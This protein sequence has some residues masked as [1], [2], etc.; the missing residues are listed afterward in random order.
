MPSTGAFETC[1]PGPE[2]LLAGPLVHRTPPR[3]NLHGL[4]V[5]LVVKIIVDFVGR[6]TRPAS[7]IELRGVVR[8]AF[9]HTFAETFPLTYARKYHTTTQDELTTDW[10]GPRMYRPNLE[11]IFRG[12]LATARRPTS[13][14]SPTSATRRTAGSRPTRGSRRPAR[15]S[16]S[17]RGHRPRS[18]DAPGPFRGR[19]GARYLRAYDLVDPAA[20]PC[21]AHRWGVRGGPAAA[22][23]LAFTSVVMVNLGVDRARHHRA[24]TSRT[25]T[26][27]TSSSRGSASRTGSHRTPCRGPGQHPG[28]DL[29]LGASTGR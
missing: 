16:R 13:T 29:R 28:R 5:D 24:P 15:T 26:T 18:A 2:Q 23:R 4:P 22:E 3:C 12:A 8:A 10:L 1:R 11:E 27:R 17:A 20:R 7:E 9:G 6:R 19:T 21:P 14:T 25:S